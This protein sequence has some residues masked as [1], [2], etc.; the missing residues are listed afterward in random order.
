[1]NKTRRAELARRV[2][3][4]YVSGPSAATEAKRRALARVA[5][6]RAV[7]L[8]EGVSD[9]IALEALAVRRGRDLDGE[10]VVIL[11][12][13]GAHAITGFLGR[14]GP[15]GAD[16]FLA[17]LCDANE[18]KL[19]RQGLAEAGVGTPET[20]PEM[21]RLGFHVCVDDLEDELIRSAGPPRVEALFDSQGDLGSFRTLQKQAVWRDQRIEAQMRRFLGS[22][23]RRKLRY[24]RLL[25]GVIPNNRM[26]LPLEAVLAH[27]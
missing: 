19:F 20:R 13:G 14:L 21:A 23:A 22:G 15:K 16:L 27:L 25:V 5:N 10:G 26:P 12:V 4:G 11:P 6:S 24:A 1:M 8:V 9:L 3:S 7:V 2:L 18:A 17:G